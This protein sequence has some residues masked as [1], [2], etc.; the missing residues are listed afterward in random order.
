M[1]ELRFEDHGRID[2]LEAWELQ[3]QIHAEVVEGTRP[4]T[5]LLL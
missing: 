1:S 5:V 2:Y 3:K 4:D